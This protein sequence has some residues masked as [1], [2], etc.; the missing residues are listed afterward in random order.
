M[1][2]K[3][4][5]D[6]VGYPFDRSH[7]FAS[8]E[9]NVMNILMGTQNGIS[10]EYGGHGLADVDDLTVTLPSTLVFAQ[11]GWFKNDLPITL[12]IQPGTNGYIVA[13][14]DLSEANTSVGAIDDGT[15]QYL[16]NQCQYKV[17]TDEPV[18][19]DLNNGGVRY[20]VVLYA[21]T[22]D[23]SKVTLTDK[24]EFLRA[25]SQIGDMPMILTTDHTFSPFVITSQT[26][27]VTNG[28]KPASFADNGSSYGLAEHAGIV[29]QQ[30]VSTDAMIIFDN[31]GFNPATKHEYPILFILTGRANMSIA[32]GSTAKQGNMR[33][34]RR[35]RTDAGWG[36]WTTM[37]DTHLGCVN[38]LGPDH[39]IRRMGL[40]LRPGMAV[41]VTPTGRIDSTTGGAS[42][43]FSAN[44]FVNAYRADNYD[45]RSTGL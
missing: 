14:V 26:T 33:F 29:S 15:Y 7:K 6:L 5:Q 18:K 20:D 11:G 38:G 3:W 2:N 40:L 19:E 34:L 1:I 31:G 17:I 43:R 30:M 36:D 13:Q 37:L 45:G 35:T 12:N 25:A 41:A 23:S 9:R 27:P 39:P 22:A 24:R 8:E 42:Y 4:G 21:Y 10:R 32:T 28:P 44:V 16:L